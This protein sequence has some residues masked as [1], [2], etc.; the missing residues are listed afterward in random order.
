M[1]VTFSFRALTNGCYKIVVLWISTLIFWF[2]I[3]RA[4]EE[5]NASRKL[6]KD[7]RREKKGKKLQEDTSLGLHV[8]VYR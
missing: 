6:T 1:S 2:Y 5:A 8:A 3:C 4:H 7:Q